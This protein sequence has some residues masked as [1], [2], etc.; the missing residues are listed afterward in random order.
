MNRLVSSKK[1]E[2]EVTMVRMVKAKED[3]R[4]AM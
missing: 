1:E 3:S 4:N 2:K